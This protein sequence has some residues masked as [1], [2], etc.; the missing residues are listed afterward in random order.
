MSILD[1]EPGVSDEDCPEANS[2][3]GIEATVLFA[4]ASKNVPAFGSNHCI[5]GLAEVRESSREA[6][7]AVSSRW[8]VWMNAAALN[9]PAFLAVHFWIRMRANGMR[10][11]RLQIIVNATRSIGFQRYCLT[12]FHL[13]SCPISM[14]SDM[15]TKRSH[16]ST[17]LQAD[18]EID[19]LWIVYYSRKCPHQEPKLKYHLRGQLPRI[20][21]RI[22][23]QTTL[24]ITCVPDEKR[25]NC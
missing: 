7:T 2:L 4:Q 24:K 18:N 25:L 17:T 6:N 3:R 9:A 20:I 15:R 12:L 11:R 21:Q 14:P 19:I 1:P 16:D 10:H 22:L 13:Q 5:E 23:Y 8:R